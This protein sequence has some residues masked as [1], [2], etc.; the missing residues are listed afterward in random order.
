[1]A[2]Y[3]DEFTVA[4]FKISSLKYQRI[5]LIAGGSL[6]LI[7]ESFCGY[8][9]HTLAGK[10][11]AIRKDYSTVNNITFGLLSVYQWRDQ[12]V[13][14]VTKQ[15]RD[16]DLTPAQEDSLQ[17]EISQLLYSLI[18]RV[19]NT[20]KESGGSIGD[21]LKSWAIGA[22]IDKEDLKKQVPAFSRQILYEIEKPSSK[23]RLKSV[24]RQKLEEW[25]KETYDSSRQ[26]ENSVVDSLFNKYDVADNNAFNNKTNTSL[27]HIR[28]KTYTYAFCMLAVIIMILVLWRLL[29]KMDRLHPALYILSILSALILLVVGLT[30]TM[31]EVDARI[32]SLDFHLLGET[33]SFR[34]QVLYFQSKSIVDVVRIL[35]DTGKYDSIIVGVLI[36]CFSILFP[37]TKLLSTGIYLMSK[38]SWA[39]HKVIKYFAFKSGKW[40]MADVMVVAIFMAYVGFNGILENELD[41]LNVQTDYI[42]SISTN[43]TSLQPGYIVFVGFVLYGLAL[44]E[45]LK[46]ITKP[47]K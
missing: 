42:T 4:L 27:L 7:A 29:R 5:L 32:K 40:S 38:K 47:E 18:D 10:H 35:V 22:F 24:A 36:L 9:L 8:K 11:E 2:G 25:S 19:Y 13:S 3:L 46:R 1:M 37:V 23:E 28:Q 31:I 26:T 17:K 12:I 20:I 34:N 21:K 14:S 6:L 45:I 39:K 44:S 41:S 16:F 30:T 15:I 33:I 43:A